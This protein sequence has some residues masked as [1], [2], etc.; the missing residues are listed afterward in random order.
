MQDSLCI[1][2]HWSSKGPQ[3][4]VA[5]QDLKNNQETLFMVRLQK[6][7]EGS[8][9]TDSEAL[10]STPAVPR[11]FCVT[12]GHLPPGAQWML[13][14]TLT[15]LSNSPTRICS[16]CPQP[17][18]VPQHQ[19]CRQMSQS[20][21]LFLYHAEYQS[22]DLKGGHWSLSQTA[23]QTVPWP[24]KDVHALQ[25]LSVKSPGELRNLIAH[26]RLDEGRNGQGRDLKSALLKFCCS[27]FES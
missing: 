10:Y 22:N 21:F 1:V 12:V 4:P 17:F 9:Q 5:A 3:S 6:A 24:T 26:T 18:C 23:L 7:G 27:D 16:A 14:E 20:R 13:S 25:S 2:S 19:P 8:G 15:C 11:T